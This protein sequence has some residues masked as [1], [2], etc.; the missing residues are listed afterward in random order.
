M[1]GMN[2]LG[3]G[4][5]R[6]PAAPRPIDPDRFRSIELK[7]EDVEGD[8]EYQKLVKEV[9]EGVGGRQAGWLFG[10]GAFDK[11]DLHYLKEL[12]DKRKYADL[13]QVEQE[14][15]TFAMQRASFEKGSSGADAVQD[16]IEQARK[17]KKEAATARTQSKVLARMVKVKRPGQAGT[18][19]SQGQ[20][21][22]DEG[23]S[24]EA[25]RARLE[26]GAAKGQAAAG[27]LTGLLGDYGSD[28]EDST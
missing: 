24:Q 23:A 17:V 18:G 3:S 6:P 12:E 21:H 20:E 5:K 7:P 28:S 15:A 13:Q 10:R 19:D 26:D 27:G 4:P 14:K 8:L 9:E 25:K 11:T 1:A 2:R 22:P 16:L